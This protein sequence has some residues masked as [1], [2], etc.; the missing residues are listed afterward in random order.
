MPARTRK[1]RHDDDYAG[2]VPWWVNLIGMSEAERE[3]A[4]A[5][6]WSKGS[7]DGKG[8]LETLIT[9]DPRNLK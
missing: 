6:L 8:G 4:V 1:V 7:G 2:Y 9:S 5:E 3:A